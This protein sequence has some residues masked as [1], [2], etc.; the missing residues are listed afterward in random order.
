VTDALRRPPRRWAI[1][2]IAV[3]AACLIA[4]LT[5]AGPAAA[6]TTLIATDP[7]D[8]AV[9]AEAPD[10][11][12]LT[13]N[14]HVSLPQHGVQV[15][16]ARGEP[17]NSSA[18]ASD[19]VVTVDLPDGLEHGTYVVAWRV[20]SADGHPVAGSLTFSVGEPSTT[21]T[22]PAAPTAES[23][24]VTSVLSA[25]Q[26]VTYLGLL[27]AVG[28]AIFTVL[29]LP[30][31]AGAKRPRRWIRQLLTGAAITSVL[32]ALLALPLTAIN[33]QGI[34]LARL[35]SPTGWNGIQTE[36]VLS[37]I[38]MT[39]GLAAVGVSVVGRPAS[40]GTRAALAL[41]VALAAV[42]PALTGHSR[43]YGPPLLVFLVDVLHI[44]AGSVW[45][46][47]LVGLALALSARPDRAE[48][49]RTLSR[50]ST[51]AASVLAVL[52]GSGVLL[53]WRIVGSWEN[54]FHTSYGWLLLTKVGMVS[55]AALI[56]AWNR[57]VL[58]PRAQ[59]ATADPERRHATV[60]LGRVVSTEAVVIV[61]VLVF[62]GFLVNQS[63][64]VDARE[65]SDRAAG[66][67]R[68]SLG[69]DV[70]VVA[71]LA[72]GRVG[73]NTLTVQLQDQ[74]GRAWR[75]KQAPVMSLD[76]DALDLGRISASAKTGA[77]ATFRAHIVIPSSGSWRL[78]VSVRLGKFENPVTTVGFTV[79]D[80]EK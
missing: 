14:E 58:M 26:A 31:E 64:E 1:R 20:I 34:P 59:Q 43:G 12:A 35:F 75:P 15:F 9:L 55:T 67:Q 11:A 19:A 45:F 56:A 47:G 48:A 61:M 76:S 70:E 53:A 2:L 80:Q 10:H 36:A 38:M 57:F 13:F 62:T 32:A 41:G 51:L 17:V 3:A 24:A 16:D 37:F 65:A 63:P 46:G 33:Q 8:G 21:I 40:R 5:P 72:P 28:L 30:A 22:S 6:H 7:V 49:T 77:P 71:T 79:D 23:S 69:E 29:V 4:I 73:Q 60:R 44:V 25:T 42:A 39:V 66:M 74:H 27:L 78:H 50:F 52:L 54:L 68:G 18:S